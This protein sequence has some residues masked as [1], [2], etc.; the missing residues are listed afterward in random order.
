MNVRL[1]EYIV[2]ISE[3]K[4]ITKAAAE[5]F[6][7]QSALDQQLIKLEKELGTQLF[8]RSKMIFR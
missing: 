3:K 4:S 5:L 8:H 7:T 1:L 2:K 6:I